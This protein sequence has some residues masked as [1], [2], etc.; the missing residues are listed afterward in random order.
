MTKQVTTL[1]LALPLMKPGQISSRPPQFA[2][3][4]Q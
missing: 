1:A 2:H 3:L 4:Q